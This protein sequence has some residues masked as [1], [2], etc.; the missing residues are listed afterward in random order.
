MNKKWIIAVSLLLLLVACKKNIEQPEDKVLIIS[1]E[2][3]KENDMNIIIGKLEDNIYINSY[4]DIRFAL[5]KNWNE[6]T[7]SEMKVLLKGGEEILNVE[8]TEIVSMIPLFATFK[9]SIEDTVEVNPNIIA[10]LE[11]LEKDTSIGSGKEYLEE[12]KEMLLT[13]DIPYSVGEVEE[14]TIEN[15]TYGYFTAK[16]DTGE[17]IVYQKYYTTIIK[18]YSI[19]II[20]TYVLEEDY[21]TIQ[22]VMTSE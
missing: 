16:I 13:L 2:S 5:P 15:H 8:D 4:F 19:N 6:L 18:G 10:T 12:M 11:V 3:D 14:V 7:E 22:G 1:E 21:K 17:T 20:A 9:Y